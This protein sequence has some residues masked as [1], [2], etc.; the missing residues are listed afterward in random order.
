MRRQLTDDVVLDFLVDL[1]QP[2]GDYG[3][4][5][6][7]GAHGGDGG[8]GRRLCSGYSPNYSDV[9]SLTETGVVLCRRH[10]TAQSAHH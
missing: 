6:D 1:R 8:D 9:L 4:Q 5:V 7:T 10:S 3:G 2:F